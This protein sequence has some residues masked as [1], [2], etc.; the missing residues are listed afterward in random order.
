[1]QLHM[2][3]WPYEAKNNIKKFHD[4]HVYYIIKDNNVLFPKHFLRNRHF[5]L[6]ACVDY[7]VD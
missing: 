5:P 4:D 2:L 6:F 7:K 3:R 1:M